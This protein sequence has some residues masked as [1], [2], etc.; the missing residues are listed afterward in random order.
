MFT[1][2]VSLKA[3]EIAIFVDQKLQ[4]ALL[5][6]NFFFFFAG[7]IAAM[8]HIVQLSKPQVI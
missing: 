8:F 3:D 2:Q 4:F 1:V 6:K 7:E 5:K